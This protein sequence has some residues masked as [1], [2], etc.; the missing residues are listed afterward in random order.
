MDGFDTWAKAI[1][2]VLGQI[3]HQDNRH[4]RVIHFG[5]RVYRLTTF[6]PNTTTTRGYW[7]PLSFFTV[8]AAL[9]GSPARG[10]AVLYCN[11]AL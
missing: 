3:A 8:V 6:L 10:S 1:T 4:F 9:I 2:A 5:T 11:A 7:S